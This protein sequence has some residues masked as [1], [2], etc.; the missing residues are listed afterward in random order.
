M[1]GEPWWERCEREGDT[2]RFRCRCTH[3]PKS[4]DPEVCGAML[5]VPISHPMTVPVE[6]WRGH[7]SWI[8]P[9]KAGADSA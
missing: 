8:E 6:C 2:I 3:V 4:G 5:T 9:R 7:S 1:S